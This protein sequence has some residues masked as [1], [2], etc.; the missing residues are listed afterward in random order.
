[1]SQPL[2]GL[3]VLD[4]SRLLPGPLATMHLADL[5]AEVLKLESPAKPDYLRFLEPYVDG[6]NIAFTTLNRGKKSL[7]VAF[8]TQVGSELIRELVKTCDVLV[9]SFRAGYLARFG[10][11]YASLSKIHPELIYCS[12][13]AFGQHSSR[14]GHDLNCLALSGLS[15]SL[16]GASKPNVPGTQLADIGCAMSASQAILAALYARDRGQ[17]GTHLDI[18]M[19][20]A[21][22]HLVM[23]DSASAR[24]GVGSFHGDSLGGEQGYYRYYSCADGRTLAVGAL[25]EKFHQPILEALGVESW[26]EAETVFSQH[27]LAHWVKLL[28]PLD[29]CVEPVLTPT[30]VLEADWMQQRFGSWDTV[31]GLL[32]GCFPGS[33]SS[34]AIAGEHTSE[35]LG[36]PSE[37][38]AEL[39]EAG[40]ILTPSAL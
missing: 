21:A 18:S 15:H 1:M 38:L 39:S 5:G 35:V 36:L 20:D 3:R 19:T 16:A 29:A 40:V 28:G 9:E 37:R 31:P 26:G 32:Q 12:I 13:T 33:S 7:V 4:L 8:E 17:G 24:A 27:D 34:C 25:E 14:A 10:L 30:E 23:L 6:Q 11:D 2:K 22:Y